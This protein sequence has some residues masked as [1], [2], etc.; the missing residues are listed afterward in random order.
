MS[1]DLHNNSV[2]TVSTATVN[3]ATVEGFEMA[4]EASDDS[5]AV[6]KTSSKPMSE[7]L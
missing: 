7:L 4:I 6:V 2:A 1:Q 3:S 5:A